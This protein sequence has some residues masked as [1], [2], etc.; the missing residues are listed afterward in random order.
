[1]LR[2][3]SYNL[4]EGLRPVDT[5]T[6][7]RREPERRALDRDRARAALEVVRRLDPDVLVLNE[8]LFCRA[9]DGREVDYGGL[10]GF[11]HQACALYDGAWGNAILSRRPIVDQREMRIHNRGGLAAELDVGDGRLTVAS[12]H[13]HPGRWPG[14]RTLDFVRLLADLEGPRILAGDL[15]CIN[16]ADQPDRASLVAAFERFSDE[17]AEAVDRFIDAGAMVFAAL[18]RQGLRDAMPARSRRY[19]IPTDLLDVDKRSGMRIDHVLVSEEIEIVDA[20]VV[21][22]EPA[23]RASDHYPV[24]ID[25]TLAR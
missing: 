4:L 18:E 5:R 22:G 20:E 19:T 13:P 14:N 24:R 7:P 15:N 8:A 11:P 9:H 10:F 1:V 21:H 2:L 25:F 16:P 17:P 6:R 12:Y 3:V 23:D